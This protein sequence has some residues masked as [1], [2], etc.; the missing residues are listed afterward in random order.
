MYAPVDEGKSSA[1]CTQCTMTSIWCRFIKILNHCEAAGYTKLTDEVAPSKV[2]R[3]SRLSKGPRAVHSA[4]QRRIFSANVQGKRGLFATVTRTKKKSRR[5]DKVLS[6]GRIIFVN[7]STNYTSK[8]VHFFLVVLTLVV[9]DR[10][11]EHG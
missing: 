8:M 2:L 3:D 11:L 1:K 7:L 6:N 9:W 4:P 10:E 5:E